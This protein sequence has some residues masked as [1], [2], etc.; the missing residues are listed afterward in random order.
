MSLLFP[1]CYFEGCLQ[2]EGWLLSHTYI[3]PSMW[4]YF[5]F[6]HSHWDIL[7]FYSHMDFFILISLILMVCMPLCR[8]FTLFQ[9]RQLVSLL[10]KH[11]SDP[12]TPIPLGTFIQVGF[13]LQPPHSY[14]FMYFGFLLSIPM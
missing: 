12:Y 5:D 6:V 11:L 7:F 13:H 14:I 10:C 4:S 3:T 2:G 9:V 1:L 8:A